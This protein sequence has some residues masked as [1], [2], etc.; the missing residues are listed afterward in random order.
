[1]QIEPDG[2]AH[3][4]L[5]DDLKEDC[6]SCE[7]VPAGVVF[8]DHAAF[9]LGLGRSKIKRSRASPLSA[10]MS[11]VIDS[12]RRRFMWERACPRSLPLIL[13]DSQKIAGKPAPTKAKTA[14]PSLLRE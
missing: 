12:A 11:Q 13:L 14:T 2:L 6:T 8:N 5:L 9:V 1:L 3:S 7:K 10:N 4:R